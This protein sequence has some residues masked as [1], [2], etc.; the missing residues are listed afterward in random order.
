MMLGDTML[1]VLQNS[2]PDLRDLRATGV[3]KLLIVGAMIPIRLVEKHSR[4]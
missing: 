4:S 1:H 2:T 3:R